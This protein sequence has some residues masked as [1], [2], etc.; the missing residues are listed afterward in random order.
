MGT[1][2]LRGPSLMEEA[3]LCPPGERLLS[4]GGNMAPVPWD[5]LYN[6]QDRGLLSSSSSS[7]EERGM[8]F[9]L[10]GLLSDGGVMATS[11]REILI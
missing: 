1:V 5:F 7:F 9:I 2:A 6:G 3:W 4:D 10:G 11:L 8:T